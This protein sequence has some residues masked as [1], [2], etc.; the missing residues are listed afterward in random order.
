MAADSKAVFKA[1]VNT[2]GLGDHYETFLEN[3]WSTYAE[4]AFATHA[5][6]GQSPEL[7]DEQ[8]LIPAL[9]NTQH[10]DRNRLLRLFYEA[11]AIASG[12]IR[13]LQD[14]STP[15]VVRT[16][17]QPE[18][19]AR[20]AE[21]ASQLR[22]LSVD[23]RF[24]GELD[25][26]DRL[27][28]RCIDLWDKNAVAY[29]PLE[30]CTKR[31]FEVLGHRRD[32]VMAPMQDSNG[33]LRMQSQQPD[34]ICQIS[35]QSQ[36]ENAHT[37]RSLAMDMADVMSFHLGDRLRRTLVEALTTEV[38]P[39]HVTVDL[40]QLVTAD[41][42]FWVKLANETF[43]KVKREGEEEMPCDAKAVK[44]MES[45]AFQMLLAPRAVLPGAAH[46][47]APPRDTVPRLSKK[48][49]KVLQHQNKVSQAKAVREHIAG[50]AAKGGQGAK[51]KG[52]GAKGPALIRLPPGLEGM[53]TKTSAAT[54]MRR[55][56]F[57]FNLGTCQAASPGNACAKGLHGC[58]K[59]VGPQGEACGGTHTASACTI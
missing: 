15:D 8:I 21:L 6:P 27:M 42:K 40:N 1:R 49:K 17:P 7:Y 3:S 9:G 28:E 13:R 4:F 12:E 58:M 35:N 34:A 32:P 10:K 47:A 56:C 19:E 25:I 14:P 39:G 38:P 59:P 36:W 23:G 53:A 31:D 26:S 55:L 20:R 46:P 30:L 43:G 37:R 41:K 54:G 50:T 44:V 48:E 2:L 24:V 22:G 33:Y 51:A 57:G 16:I 18:K 29:V 5:R 11:F 45:V 52:K